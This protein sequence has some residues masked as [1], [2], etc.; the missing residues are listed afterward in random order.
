MKGLG[1]TS[2]YVIIFSIVINILAYPLLFLDFNLRQDYIQEYLCI[3]REEPI[4]VCGGHCYLDAQLKKQ[5]SDQKKENKLSLKTTV[6]F[7]YVKVTQ[8]LPFRDE[9]SLIAIGPLY[10]STLYN[11][12]IV[13]GIFRPPRTSFFLIG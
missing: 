8:L 6:L 3:N 13:S 5:S 12:A 2:I 4:T 7:F 9:D 11:D 1:I 10:K